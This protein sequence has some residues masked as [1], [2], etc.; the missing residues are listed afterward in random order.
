MDFF[1]IWARFGFIPLFILII[2]IQSIVFWFVCN[3]KNEKQWNNRFYQRVEVFEDSQVKPSVAW[4][5]LT[6]P[7]K[8]MHLNYKNKIKWVNFEQPMNL[9]SAV[10]MSLSQ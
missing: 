1:E 5:F 2:A 10:R 3:F 8:F 4:S 6:D 9:G 7:N